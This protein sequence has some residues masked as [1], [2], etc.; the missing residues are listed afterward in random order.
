[1]KSLIIFSKLLPILLLIGFGANAQDK[2]YRQNGDIINSKVIEVG[3]DAIKYKEFD[4]PDGPIYSVDPDR[5]SKIVFENGK[6]HKVT[7]DIN[8]FDKEV[9]I[10]QRERIIK[11]NFFAPLMGYSE[12]S[13]QQNVKVGQSWQASLGIIGAGKQREVSYDYM[14]NA[15][16][17]KQGGLFGSFGYRFNNVPNYITRGSRLSHIMHGSYIQPTLYLGYYS[18]NTA[19]YGYYGGSRVEKVGTTFGNIQMEFGKQWV[20]SNRLSL[21]LYVGLGIGFDNKAKKT[22][23]DTGDFTYYSFNYA[24]M[25]VGKSPGFGFTN[26]VKIG[27]LFDWSK[28]KKK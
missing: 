27:Y 18:E 17:S 26:G 13:Y 28:S 8:K 21:D 20:F 3:E 4:N 25:R 12:V 14:G 16:Y 10:G 7:K 9:Y 23:S 6:V 19:T 1:M 22:P 5:V 24:A 2:I 15:I 11:F